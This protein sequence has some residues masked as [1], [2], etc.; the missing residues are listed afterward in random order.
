[1][2]SPTC[3]GRVPGFFPPIKLHA[4]EIT[5]GANSRYGCGSV[6]YWDAPTPT[7]TA[8]VICPRSSVALMER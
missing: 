4:P 8:V 5:P 3:P 7:T 1:M 2:S 6:G